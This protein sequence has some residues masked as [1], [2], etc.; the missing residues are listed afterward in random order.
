M[1]KASL[2]GKNANSLSD[3]FSHYLP[4][5]CIHTFGCFIYL[6]QFRLLTKFVN[7]VS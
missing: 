4:R 2:S 3:I 1:G 5:W 7:V 6:L